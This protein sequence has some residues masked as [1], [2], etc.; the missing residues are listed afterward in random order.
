MFSRA[1]IG[2]VVLGLAATPAL[3]QPAACASQ[4]GEDVVYYPKAAQ[5]QGV[6]GVA[7]IKCKVTRGGELSG[8]VVVSETPAGYCFGRAALDMAV[9]LKLKERPAD[10]VYQTTIRFN[11]PKEDAPA[12]AK[13]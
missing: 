11:L 5:A 9:T 10:G 3:A 1:A 12:T 6:E 13:P 8:C 7:V 4:A 2:A